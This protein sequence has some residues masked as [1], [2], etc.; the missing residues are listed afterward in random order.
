MDLI[1]SL[2][3]TYNVLSSVDV[4]FEYYVDCIFSQ[5]NVVSLAEIFTHP[6]WNLKWTQKLKST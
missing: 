6:Q 3:K 4:S 1:L 2:T 5:E